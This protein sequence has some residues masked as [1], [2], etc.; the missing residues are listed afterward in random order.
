MVNAGFGHEAPVNKTVEWYTPAWIFDI[1]GLTFD[2]DP[3]HPA[4]RLPWVPVRR[5]I[6]LPDDGLAE[7]WE[8][9]VWLNPPYGPET[10]KWMRVMH[11]HR[12]GVSLVF[13]R[14]GAR[15]AQDY[16]LGADGIL[17]LN[18]RVRFLDGNWQPGPF[19]PGA[20]SMLVG[21]DEECCAALARAA[22]REDAG[23]YVHL[24]RTLYYDM[25][26]TLA[27]RKDT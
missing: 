16:A 1:M 18:K 15:W 19:N 13:A 14:M 17:F 26:P 20:D 27:P 7:P 10:V 22:E 24:A 25:A 11:G 6:S 2:L 21:W 5:T 8:G 4:R 3:C 9:K 12:S 23:R